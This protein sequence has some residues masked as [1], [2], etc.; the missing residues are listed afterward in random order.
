MFVSVWWWHIMFCD[1]ST[2]RISFWTYVVF[3]YANKNRVPVD[4]FSSVNSAKNWGA[5][6]FLFPSGKKWK[7][8]EKVETHHRDQLFHH[9]GHVSLMIHSMNHQDIRFLFIICC[10]S[11]KRRAIV[12]SFIRY[13]KILVE[14]SCIEDA[15]IP[16]ILHLLHLFSASLHLFIS[17]S[18]SGLIN[19]SRISTSWIVIGG[20]R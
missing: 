12:S 6:L 2:S 15:W 20:N 3:S 17:I 5:V 4:I 18:S 19:C 7:K 14:K 1:S 16:Q 13:S 8:L 10:S 11:Y 9:D